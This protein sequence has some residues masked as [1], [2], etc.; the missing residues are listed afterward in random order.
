M[1]TDKL[2]IPVSQLSEMSADS[3]NVLAYQSLLHLAGLD[4]ACPLVLDR[5]TSLDIATV[6]S[7]L[8]K[9]NLS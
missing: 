4:T 9:D 3:I 6:D 8:F 5:I 2:R 7:K 1:T